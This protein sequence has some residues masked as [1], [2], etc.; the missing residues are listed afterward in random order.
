MRF[1]A[2]RSNGHSTSAYLFEITG[3]RRRGQR[4]GNVGSKGG[5]SVLLEQRR[6]DACGESR[7]RD[8]ER[9]FARL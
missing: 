7:G 5:G 9:V 1:Y 8:R 4:G 6:G 3:H 2:Y